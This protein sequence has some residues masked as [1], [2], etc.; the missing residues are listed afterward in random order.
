MKLTWISDIHLEF[1]TCPKARRFLSEADRGFPDPVL[2]TGDITT[3]PELPYHLQVMALDMRSPFYFVLGS[4]DFYHGSFAEVDAVVRRI[5]HTC[6]NLHVLGNGEII[7]LTRRLRSLGIA[8]G[9]RAR[10][11][12]QAIEC[13]S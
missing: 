5:C 6:P 10:G 13:P 1:L 2:I 3:A 4:H 8:A 7:P 11:P 9:R 12:R